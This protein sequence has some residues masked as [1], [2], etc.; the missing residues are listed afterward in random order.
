M[1]SFNE[2]KA[3]HLKMFPTMF[4]DQFMKQA[5]ISED[6]NRQFVMFKP[7]ITKL[8]ALSFEAGWDMRERAGNEEDAKTAKEPPTTPPS[9]S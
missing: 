4:F 3:V 2:E 1:K 9:I 5:G 6:L 8:A 7:F